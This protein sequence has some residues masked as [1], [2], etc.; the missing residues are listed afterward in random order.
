VD[1]I[2]S[3]ASSASAM[4]AKQTAELNKSANAAKASFESAL[5]RART[6]LVG[7]PAT[8]FTGGATYNANSLTA[9]TGAALSSALS[10]VKS[11]VTIKPTTGFK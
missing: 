5:S 2:S 1:S 8:G 3:I 6:T 11:A 7:R 4:I 10:S 9:R